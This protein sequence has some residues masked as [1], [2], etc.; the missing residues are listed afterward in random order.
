MTTAKNAPQGRVLG[1]ITIVSLLGL[2]VALLLECTE[3]LREV[4]PAFLH[5]RHSGDSFWREI[6]PVFPRSVPHW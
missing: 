3:L 4:L 2:L 6:T 5:I 1:S